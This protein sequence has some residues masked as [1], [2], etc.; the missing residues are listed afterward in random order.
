MST[1]VSFSNYCNE[2]NKSY[3]C[4][5]KSHKLYKCKKEDKIKESDTKMPNVLKQMV[6]QNN[7]LL[8]QNKELIE[9]IKNKPTVNNNID[10]SVNNI[11]N[12][13]NNIDNSVNNNFNLNVFLNE[14]CKDAINFDEFIDILELPPN[15]NL[16][17]TDLIVESFTPLHI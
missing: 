9:L 3:K 7:E 13:V 6:H 5:E 14:T 15:T 11:D 17:F 1:V 16:T 2:C 8:Q 10:N 12:S 4:S